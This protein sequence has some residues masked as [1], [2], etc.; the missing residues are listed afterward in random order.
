MIAGRF[1]DREFRW[2]RH[3][4][5]RMSTGRGVRLPGRTHALNRVANL[6][7]VETVERMSKG[8]YHV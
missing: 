2:R 8:G 1:H 5:A 3:T 6:G 4:G 7:G